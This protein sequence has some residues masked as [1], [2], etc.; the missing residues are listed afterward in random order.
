MNEPQKKVVKV[1]HFYS[2]WNYQKAI[3]FLMVLGEIEVKD[4]LTFFRHCKVAWKDFEQKRFYILGSHHPIFNPF[5]ANFLFYTPYKYQ[6][7]WKM[8]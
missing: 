3:A 1:P 6:K 4:L 8:V 7:T 2:P 5:Q